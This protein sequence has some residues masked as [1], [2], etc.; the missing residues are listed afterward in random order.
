M[1]R[2]LVSLQLPLSPMVVFA[3]G[4]ERPLDVSVQRS[5]DADAR[6]HCRTAARPIGPPS[7]ASIFGKAIIH[8]RHVRRRCR[9]LQSSNALQNTD[10]KSSASQTAPAYA[11]LP[12]A[13]RPIVIHTQTGVDSR[14]GRIVGPPALRTSNNNPRGWARA[15]RQRSK[16]RRQPFSGIGF[17]RLPIGPDIG[18]ALAT[19]LDRRDMARRNGMTVATAS[20]DR[21]GGT[22]VSS[23]RFCNVNVVMTRSRAG[24]FY[25]NESGRE[26]SVHG[27]RGN[28][29]QGDPGRRSKLPK[30]RP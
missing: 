18:A 23:N 12:R 20:Y 4:I 1:V 3:I 15:A 9:C 14:R 26:T 10:I 28:L 13:I 8:F 17:S 30:L 7:A 22:A 24:G 5:Y 19:S 27:Y 6:E 11:R 29:P 2:S 21:Y 16:L 25:W